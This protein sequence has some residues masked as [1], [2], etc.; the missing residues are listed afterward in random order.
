LRERGRNLTTLEDRPAQATS[1]SYPDN[2]NIDVA[3]KNRFGA[4]CGK[5]T[6]TFVRIHEVPGVVSYLIDDSNLPGFLRLISA[7]AAAQ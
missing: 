6:V 1:N 7:C 4:D 2:P 5:A 3:F